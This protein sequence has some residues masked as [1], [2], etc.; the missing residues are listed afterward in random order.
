MSRTSSHRITIKKGSFFV[1]YFSPLVPSELR[2]KKATAQQQENVHSMNPCSVTMGIFLNV[3]K[4]SGWLRILQA[5]YMLLHFSGLNKLYLLQNECFLRAPV[6]ADSH[7]R[8]LAWLWKGC[9]ILSIQSNSVWSTH[10]KKSIQLHYTGHS[11]NMENY[12]L[13]GWTRNVEDYSCFWDI[14]N[15]WLVR[16]LEHVFIYLVHSFEH[17]FI[18]LIY[19]L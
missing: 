16:A 17:W 14:F 6:K 5:E 8:M 2:K 19:F 12:R 15:S 10:P 4:Q 13:V 9:V 11:S 7:F 1:L 18:L 3:A